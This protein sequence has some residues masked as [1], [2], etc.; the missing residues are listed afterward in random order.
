MTKILGIAKLSSKAQVTIPKEVREI[1]ELNAK[2]KVLFIQE[3][4]KIIIRKA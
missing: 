2:D 3:D 1:M 4:E